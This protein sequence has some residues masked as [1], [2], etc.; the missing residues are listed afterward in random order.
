MSMDKIELIAT[1]P[2]GLEAVVAREV[3]ELGY[4]EITTENGRVTFKADLL[5][6]ARANLWLRTADRVLV[7][8]GQ[9]EARTFDDLFEGVKAL[10][11]PDW[12]PEDAEFPVEGRSHKSQLSSVP[13]C[14]G[15]VKKAVV[16]KMKL[17]YGTEWFRET[18]GRYVIEVALLNDIATIT[19]DTTG[20]GLH[21]RGYRKLVTEAPLKE[22][23]AAAMV[24]LSRWQAERPLYDPFCGSGTI[25]IEAAMIGWNIAPGLRRTFNSESWPVIP[26]ELWEQAREEAY[27]LVRDDVPLQITGSDIDPEAVDVAL[28][29]AK[30]AGLAKEL[31]LEVLPVSKMASRGDYGCIITNPP[32]G[33][34]LGDQREAERAVRQLGSIYV[35]LPT[36]SAFIL[37]PGKQLELHIGRPSDKKRKLFNGRI[38]CNL[39]QYFAPG[40][41][42]GWRKD[43]GSG[44]SPEA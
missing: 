41:L 34:R 30:A 24:L 27:D 2:M 40:G 15:I 22:T 1:A 9:F 19:L 4:D 12:I 25:P 20:P 13:A 31:R 18:G 29:A 6:I 16:E 23:M 33:E 44:K 42:Y 38:E 14:Q 8:M 28:A 10:P 35:Q 26:Q 21:K 43:N 5:A 39:Y 37:S 11:W 7:K 17:E 32:Y 3:R 36:W